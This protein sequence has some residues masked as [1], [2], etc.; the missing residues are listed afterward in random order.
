[1]STTHRDKSSGKPRQRSRK[2]DQRG[3]K[4]EKRQNPKLDQRDEDQVGPMIASTDAPTSPGASA[5]VPLSGEIEPADMPPIGAIEP[6]DVTSTGVTVLADHHP[7]NIQA[8][9]NAYR[10]YTRKSFNESRFFVE[11]LMGIRS[12]DQAVEIQTE[13]ARLAYANF[14]AE[15]QKMCELYNEFAKQAFW[16]WNELAAREN[17]AGR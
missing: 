17:Q 9:A 10:D 7:I 5:V 4:A 14:V 6:A 3:Q 1:M 15:S 12:F 11:K 8:I 16:P 13:F 2:T